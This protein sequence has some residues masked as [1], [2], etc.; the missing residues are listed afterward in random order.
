MRKALGIMLII[1]S[2]PL[3]IFLFNKIGIEL[4]SAKN[5]SKQFS[6]AIEIKDQQPI[7][8]TLLKDQDN[9]LFSEE[10]SE[11]RDPL[12]LGDIPSFAQQLFVL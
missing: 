7:N 10:Y 11:W 6:S 9:V 5:F 3:L 4:I 8:P 2:L 12:K 1:C